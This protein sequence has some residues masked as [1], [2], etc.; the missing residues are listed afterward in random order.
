MPPMI[1]GLGMHLISIFIEYS[2]KFLGTIVVHLHHRASAEFACFYKI[3]YPV[4]EVTMNLQVK[5][6][7]M[8]LGNIMTEW[9]L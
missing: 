1:G 4:I 3:C 2:P 5:F 9:H 6:K 8:K 7:I